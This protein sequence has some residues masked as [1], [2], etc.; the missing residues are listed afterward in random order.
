MPPK[1]SYFTPKKTR[2]FFFLKYWFKADFNIQPLQTIAVTDSQTAAGAGNERDPLRDTSSSPRLLFCLHSYVSLCLITFLI[3]GV[4]DS[5][6]KIL[7]NRDK[8]AVDIKLMLHQAS[9]TG[10]NSSW[11]A[12][13]IQQWLE[14]QKIMLQLLA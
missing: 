6:G 3:S 7:A 11:T 13:E 2:I 5:Y 14:P 12:R 8:A 1:W 4:M 10:I 9:L